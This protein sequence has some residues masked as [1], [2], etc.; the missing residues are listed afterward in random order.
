MQGLE[1]HT[2]TLDVPKRYALGS[3]K[4]NLLRHMKEVGHLRLRRRLEE[5]KKI[6]F[7]SHHMQLDMYP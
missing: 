4:T 5:N 7:G 1:T 6:I 2:R 3:N